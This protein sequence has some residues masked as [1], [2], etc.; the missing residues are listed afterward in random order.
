MSFI[1]DGHSPFF[2]PGV[3]SSGRLRVLCKTPAQRRWPTH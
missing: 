2:S 1:E 3:L